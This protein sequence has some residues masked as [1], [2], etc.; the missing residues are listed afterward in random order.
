MHKGKHYCYHPEYW[1]TVGW[2]WPGYCPWKLAVESNGTNPAPFDAAY[3]PGPVV[4]D[5]G[6]VDVS[7][8]EIT[9]HFDVSSPTFHC[10]L[11]VTMD[12]IEVAGVKKCRWR[13]TIGDGVNWWATAY[14]LQEFPQYVV[15]ID[16]WDWSVP[17]PPYLPNPI[18]AIAL[19]PATWQESGS[20]YPE[21][22][23]PW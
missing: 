8:T 13:M 6:E 22:D 16:Q 3:L 15:G 7:E 11:V 1:A 18:P 19:R 20:P 2:F 21:P 10:E 5:V 17:Q 9:Y 12:T 14:A 4:S 23:H